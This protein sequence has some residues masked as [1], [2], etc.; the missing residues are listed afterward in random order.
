[1]KQKS[2]YTIIIILMACYG[3]G[4]QTCVG[5]PG[6][7]T[8]QVYRGLFDDEI[9]ELLSWPA[10]PS[11]PYDTKILYNTKSIVN[12][13]NAMGATMRGFI[14]VPQSD[15][16]TFNLT[17]NEQARFY[18]STN[19]NPTNKVLRAYTN[20]STN[21]EEYTKYAS[22]TSVKIY[23]QTGINYYFE[24]LYVDYS[25]SD[26]ANLFWKAPFVDINNWKPI[27]AGFFKKYFVS[28]CF[29]STYEYT[30]R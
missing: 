12:Y 26:F 15:S 20:L 14:Y 2:I 19:E 17:G 8:W 16:V 13:D 18:L 27:T 1:M 22:Q 29:L 28:S 30:L 3:Y 21:A 7:I 11:H 10:Y 5:T 25:G 24:I 9:N 4:Q 23:L 6:Q